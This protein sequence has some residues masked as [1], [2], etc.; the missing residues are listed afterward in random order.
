[1]WKGLRRPKNGRKDAS[2]AEIS[3]DPLSPTVL[4]YSSIQTLSNI[5][6]MS[7]LMQAS[8]GGHANTIPFWIQTHP[9]VDKV[10]QRSNI[11]IAVS[12]G[13]YLHIFSMLRLTLCYQEV[14]RGQLGGRR[15][16]GS[17]ATV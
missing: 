8:Y 5:T 14:G 16:G 12:T 17:A 11:Q 4:L 9:S 6:Y 10:L 3:Y 2:K 13:D 1:M 15:G 7:G